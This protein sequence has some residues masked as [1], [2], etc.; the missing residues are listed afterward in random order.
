MRLLYRGLGLIL[1]GLYVI[2]ED[3]YDF[4]SSFENKELI[5]IKD[6]EIDGVYKVKA[7]LGLFCCV[8]GLLSIVNYFFY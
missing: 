8:L 1:I 7:L 3:F 6:V 4:K 2:F 5:K